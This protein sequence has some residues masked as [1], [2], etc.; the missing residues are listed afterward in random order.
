MRI[1]K[2]TIEGSLS[3]VLPIQVCRAFGWEV[4]DELDYTINGKSLILSK[5]G[6]SA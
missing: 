5:V 3:V 1:Q 2:Q 6:E 4:G